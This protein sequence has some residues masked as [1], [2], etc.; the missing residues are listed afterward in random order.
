MQIGLK[1]AYKLN[2]EQD[3]VTEIKNSINRP[4]RR[5]YSNYKALVLRYLI[6]TI[7]A[8]LPASLTLYSRLYWLCDSIIANQ[9]GS[10]SHEFG[11]ASKKPGF[12]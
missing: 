1:S 11:N 12:T 8:Y 3:S 4:V 6:G 2:R 7:M 5:R 10:I 9:G